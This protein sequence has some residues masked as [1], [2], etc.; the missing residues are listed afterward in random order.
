MIAKENKRAL[1]TGGAGFVGAN[2]LPLLIGNGYRVRVLDDFSHGQAA[3]LEGLDIDVVEGDILNPRLV[4]KLVGEADRVVHLAAQTG[5][6]RSIENPR[7]DCE[8]NVL[9]TLNILEAARLNKGKGHGIRLVF[10]SS[11]APLGRQAPPAT[12]EKVPLPISPYGASKLAAEGYCLAYHG[13]WDIGTIVFRFANLYGPYSAHK[14]S[15]VAKFVKAILK[16]DSITIDGAGDQTRDF[17]FVG[18]MCRAI[19]T[20]LEAEVSGEIFQVATGV[21]TSIG[22]LVKQLQALMGN[23]VDVQ[24]GPERQGDMLKNYSSVTKIERVLGWIPKTDLA[25]GLE[26]TV[27]WFRDWEK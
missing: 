20:A 10:A 24:H 27:A 4:E 1:V 16:G 11:N 5:V 7:K 2:L 26:Q 15:V 17:I 8:T 19:I 14:E 21:E 12:E 22:A 23:A 25:S 9:G 6:P 3:Y 13:S 18:D